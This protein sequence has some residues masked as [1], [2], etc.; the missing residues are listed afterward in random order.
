[1]CCS[2]SLTKLAKM[3]K[4][5]LLFLIVLAMPIAM[6]NG[7]PIPSKDPNERDEY[8]DQPLGLELF[9]P[10]AFEHTTEDTK[11]DEMYQSADFKLAGEETKA[12]VTSQRPD[13]QDT[14]P[15]E[16]DE[17][18]DQP[19]GLEL[20]QP[21]AFQLT[22]EDLKADEKNLPAESNLA[23]E[24]HKGDVLFAPEEHRVD[25]LFAPV[26]HRADVLFA[27]VEHRADVLFAPEEHT[28]DVQYAPKESELAPEEHKADES[29][30]PEK[31]EFTGGWWIAVKEDLATGSKLSAE[32]TKSDDTSVPAESLLTTEDTKVYEMYQPAES[33]LAGEET[34]ADV[35]SQRPDTQ[36]TGLGHEDTDY[37]YVPA[38]GK[39][40][41]YL[42]ILPGGQRMLDEPEGQDSSE[43]VRAWYHIKVQVPI[44]LLAIMTVILSGFIFMLVVICICVAKNQW[45]Q[46]SRLNEIEQLISVVVRKN[47][48]LTKER[49]LYTTPTNEEM[50]RCLDDVMLEMENEGSIRPV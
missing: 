5:L 41:E 50:E 21:M 28:G 38:L 48:R 33:K 17:Y 19:L 34:K 1:M 44:W 7:A 27:P 10:M 32:D 16:R 15:N 12:D 18:A 13:T 31:S 37:Q 49:K 22:V 24:E 11:V 14:D 3:N 39:D 2:L 23:P 42:A 9:Q 30:A 43:D 36:D 6:I 4:L 26:E 45:K 20:F 8:A 47:N 29:Y 25:V 40:Y 35:T 46:R